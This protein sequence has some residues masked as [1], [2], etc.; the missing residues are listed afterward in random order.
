MA[1]NLLDK[2][3]HALENM[4]EHYLPLIV[5][6]LEK[7]SKTQS[8]LDSEPEELW[9]LVTGELGKINSEINDAR[10][11]DDWRTYLDEL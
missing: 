9:L 2:G 6:W 5:T 3:K 4:P 1:I 10:E 8:N 11:I 7:L